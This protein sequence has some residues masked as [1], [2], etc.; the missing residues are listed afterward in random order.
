MIDCLKNIL[1]YNGCPTL[2]KPLIYLEELAGFNMLTV[3]KIKQKTETETEFMNRTIQTA[4]NEVNDNLKADLYPYFNI[5]ENLKFIEYGQFKDNE[6]FSTLV[7]DRGVKISTNN[8]D[9]QK[10]FIE[11]VLLKFN[12]S[13]TFNVKI[14]DGP[15][16]TTFLAT[17]TVGIETELILNYTATYNNIYILVDNSLFEPSKGTYHKTKAGS[18]CCGSNNGYYEVENTKLEIQGWNGTNTDNNVYGIQPKVTIMCVFDSLWC[19]FVQTT[20][21]KQLYKMNYGIVYAQEIIQTSSNDAIVIYGGREKAREQIDL[22]TYK[23]ESARK[24]F[25]GSIK[26]TLDAM[27]SDCIICNQR[28]LSYGL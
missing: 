27:N 17:V 4:I 19:N 5:S 12:N 26:Y 24:T 2:I 23:Y 21:L 18:G 10:L 7:A 20:N 15:V 25:V 28:S 6:Y 9:L 11:S 22:L 14:L 16:T 13:G 8:K 1:G 3:S